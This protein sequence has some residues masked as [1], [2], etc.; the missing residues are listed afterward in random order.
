MVFV[1][2]TTIDNYI[3]CVTVAA[4]LLNNETTHSYVWL[5]KAF[6]KAFGKAP[7]IVVTDQ[8]RA[9]RNA[10]KAEFAGLKQRLC[11]WH[12]TQKL[13][14]KAQL[15]SL[16]REIK[17]VNKKVY[18]T[19]VGCGLCKE[20]HYTKDFPL[21]EEG[22]TIDEAYYTQFGEDVN[23]SFDPQY[24]DYIELNDLDVPLEPKMNQDDTL[25]Q[26]LMKMLLSMSL[27]LNVFNSIIKD[28]G[29]QEGKKLAR[30]LIDIPIFVGNFSIISGFSIIDDMDVT[31]G[32]V[33]GML[34]CK[35]F[36]SCQMIMEKFVRRDEYEQL[37]EE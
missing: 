4:G 21:K 20:P 25:S 7:S 35:K 3:N 33:L 28:E 13:P 10:N 18:A 34:F 31:S 29:D 17:K 22:K 11:M 24:G 6:I 32:V 37:K 15:N 16:E 26:P 30:T 1:P 9:M 27:L 5:L 8:D 12:I 23:K 19:K 14:T 2:F 36:V